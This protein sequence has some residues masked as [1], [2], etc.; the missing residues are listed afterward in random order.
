M[1][2]SYSDC[3]VP[4]SRHNECA[5]KGL[6]KCWN[7][8]GRTHALHHQHTPKRSQGGK[9]CHVMLCAGHHDAIDNGVRYEGLRLRDT[10]G[11]YPDGR[12]Y[13]IRDRDNL[14]I[15]VE[16]LLEVNDGSSVSS[17]G[18]RDDS[19]GDGAVLGSGKDI[20]ADGVTTGQPR[21]VVEVRKVAEPEH[22]LAD[23]TNGPNKVEDSDTGGG[24]T[25]EEVVLA[26]TLTPPPVPGASR[27]RE[28]TS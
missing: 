9:K 24:E 13:I 3:H 20:S 1:S 16:I 7:L 26:D 2:C 28:D 19:R 18:N 10:I 23:E 17:L 22:R 27:S 25:G 21:G 12:H 8:D 14:D 15:L 6:G 5:A 11:N 4:P